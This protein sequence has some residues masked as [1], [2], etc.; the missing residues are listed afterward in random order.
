MIA[1][2]TSVT[3]GALTPSMHPNLWNSSAFRRQSFILLEES[4]VQ[5]LLHDIPSMHSSNILFGMIVV[6]CCQFR[7]GFRWA[8]VRYTILGIAAGQQHAT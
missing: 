6:P 7:T 3:I 8:V 1:E 5:D 2:S 4:I